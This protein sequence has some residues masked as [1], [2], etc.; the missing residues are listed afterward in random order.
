MLEEIKRCRVEDKVTLAGLLTSEEVY[1]LFARASV[2]VSASLE[3]G[4]PN[5]FIEAMHFGLPIV[6]TDVGGC[7][8]MVQ[9]GKTGFL[10]PPGDVDA[11]AERL[12]RLGEDHA[13]RDAFST[14]AREAAKQYDLMTVVEQFIGLYRSLTRN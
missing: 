14:A 10:V 6:S 3:E 1:A 5:V 4:F 12:R 8:E 7:R 9:E 13:L 11:M 2:Y